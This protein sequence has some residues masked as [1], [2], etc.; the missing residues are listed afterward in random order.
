MYFNVFVPG[1][2]EAMDVSHCEQQAAQSGMEEEE[3][4]EE[5]GGGEEASEPQTQE[6]ALSE[7]NEVDVKKVV[8]AEKQR[9]SRSR[10]RSS[11]IHDPD[12]FLLY[13]GDTLEQLHH[14]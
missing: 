8:T 12:H 9:G 6:P 4:H 14:R 1:A 2:E 5:A 13:L 7:Q 10:R 11:Q 3:K